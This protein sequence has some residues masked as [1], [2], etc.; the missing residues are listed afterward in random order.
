MNKNLDS[1]CWDGDGDSDYGYWDKIVTACMIVYRKF[2]NMIFY[3]PNSQIQCIWAQ[4]L[5]E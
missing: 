1:P 3:K 4:K 2:E 5:T